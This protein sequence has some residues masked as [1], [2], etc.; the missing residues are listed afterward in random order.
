[1]PLSARTSKPSVHLRLVTSRGPGDPA[2]G[3]GSGLTDAE[4]VLLCRVKGRGAFEELYR[5]HASAALA[6]AVRIQGHTLDVEDIV[7]FKRAYRD[8]MDAIGFDA[9]QADVFCAEADAAF[10]FNSDIFDALGVDT[11]IGG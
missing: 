5:R 6:L 7:H 9:E 1:M 3:R 11:S 10:S 4:L 2:K 8:G